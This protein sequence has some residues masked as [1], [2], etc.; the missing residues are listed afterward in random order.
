MS[1]PGYYIKVLNIGLHKTEETFPFFYYMILETYSNKEQLL[2]VH[3]PVKSIGKMIL[4]NSS[5][6]YFEFM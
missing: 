3:K 1:L 6:R 4:I 5:L 2:Q